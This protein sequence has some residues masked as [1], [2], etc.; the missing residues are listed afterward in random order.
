[1]LKT[2][3]I[4]TQRLTPDGLR[5]QGEATPLVSA[6]K[7]WEW[8]VV[9]A[10]TMVR[11]ANGYTLFFFANHFGWEADQRLSNYANG[12]ADFRG[13]RGPCVDA[14][15]SP[16]LGSR[17]GA[18]GCISGPGHQSVFRVG[19]GSFISYHAWDATSGCRKT[20]NSRF[21]YISPLVW[22]GGK[23]EARMPLR[24]AGAAR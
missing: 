7:H 18:A 20:D 16:L 6:D 24:P 1:M 2:A 11:H 10:P 23:P 13:P 21:M 15:S 8:R 5:L 14:P 4:W 17:M 22:N 3:W 12:Y 19:G 9:E